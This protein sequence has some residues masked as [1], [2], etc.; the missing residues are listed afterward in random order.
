MRL[1]NV[2]T[3]RLVKFFGHDIPKR[4]AIL[5]HTWGPEKEEILFDDME[6]VASGNIDKS[7]KGF[8]K[9]KRCCEQ[10]K[11]DGCMWVWID[12]CCIQSS[13]SN[14][15]GTAINSMYRWYQE[16][17]VCYA[18]LA[19]VPSGTNCNDSDSMFAKSRWF[20]RGWTLQELLAPKTVQFYDQDWA[21]IGTRSRLSSSI[22][23]ITHIPGPVL[24]GWQRVHDT[25]VAQRM[26]WAANRSTK[27]R[28][29]IAYCL[30]GLFGVNMSMIYGEGAEKAF[31]RLQQEIMK[32]VRDISILAWGYQVPSRPAPKIEGRFGGSA[33][34]LARSPFE[35]RGCRNIILRQSYAGPVDSLE[36]RGGYL[37]V[38]LPVYD[39]E[40]R[41]FAVLDC[42]PDDRTGMSLAVPIRPDPSKRSADHE[43]WIRER[44]VDVKEVPKSSGAVKT[45]Y[46]LGERSDE[47]TL[48]S[49]R[50][51]WFRIAEIAGDELEL[52]DVYPP[53]SR[54]EQ[55]GVISTYGD[56]TEMG[57][58][59][60]VL[61]LRHRLN[62]GPEIILVLWVQR[63]EDTKDEAV[64]WF[65]VFLCPAN[66]DMNLELFASNMKHMT[67]TLFEGK[68][69]D[70]ESKEMQ[71]QVT[72]KIVAGH[73]MFVVDIPSRD[74]LL[75][76]AFDLDL[77]VS[78]INAL[79]DLME[80]LRRE[81]PLKQEIEAKELLAGREG[82]S[83]LRKAATE[84]VQRLATVNREIAKLLATVNKEIAK[85]LEEKAGLEAEIGKI[86]PILE[87]KEAENRRT[88]A[89]LE[90]IRKIR[91]IQIDRIRPSASHPPSVDG[92]A[93]VSRRF[94]WMETAA[95][96]LLQKRRDGLSLAFT[97]NVTQDTWDPTPTPD[98]PSRITSSAA[99]K[100]LIRECGQTLRTE[101]E[102]LGVPLTGRLN[103][104]VLEI[105]GLTK[106]KSLAET[107]VD[108]GR[109][110]VPFKRENGR[111]ESQLHKLNSV[112]G[113]GL[114]AEADSDAAGRSTLS[115]AAQFGAT[116]I[117]AATALFRA[118]CIPHDADNQGRTPLH[119]ASEHGHTDIVAL[120]LHAG[121]DP[122]R[123]TATKGST[124]LHYASH[125]GHKSIVNQL[126]DAGADV[127]HTDKEWCTPMY[128][129]ALEGHVSVI[130]A[131]HARNGDLEK[132]VSTER[133]T[134][135]MAAA[136]EGH[137]KAVVK[138]LE[139][140][141]SELP[142][143]YRRLTAYSWARKNKCT[144]VLE[145][146]H[147]H[148][149]RKK[150]G[151]KE[152]A[153]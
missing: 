14:E 15:L 107:W 122:R 38:Q 73:P 138:L 82:L 42:C 147:E 141:A 134:P 106:M 89:E 58:R 36:V 12:T 119:Y 49:N 33:G 94:D 16:S 17:T 123:P 79:A 137:A 56:A 114:V 139:L 133:V 40:G 46:V 110:D 11:K 124:P 7:R 128:Y 60:R 131:L 18:F 28:E 111:L 143:D 39:L 51:H 59:G 150:G 65:N 72:E 102:A 71:V 116:D 140:G 69:A 108:Q 68:A 85:L 121:S 76:R 53:W 104:R 30:L 21:F 54:Q 24:E 142:Q 50:R 43:Y 31:A 125:F 35:F 47:A 13:N 97:M 61:R 27:E 132:S 19:D 118:S 101:L 92:P 120:L 20:K 95:E 152:T 145:I 99:E 41:T 26:S 146:F 44:S 34:A 70:S 6:A 98:N 83:E 9:L 151:K 149:L 78:R 77:E 130:E 103:L 81:E 117:I 127:N 105:A 86:N 64:A 112:L 52:A 57:I 55:P 100:Q 22:E 144:E 63:Q 87:A 66:Q 135:L 37:S 136:S 10:A 45:I 3:L 126:L 96:Y 115:Y 23:R 1:I 62:R 25:S 29:D 67:Q 84:S 93:G 91:D 90:S 109:G 80:T 88:T 74:T 32:S 113:S 8:T 2:E 148:N 48:P 75:A 5:S 153:S 4:Y 129:A